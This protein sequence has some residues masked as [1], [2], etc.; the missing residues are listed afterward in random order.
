MTKRLYK[1]PAQA[2][3]TGV[4]AGIA[5]YF[6]IDPTV[7]R[8]LFVVAAF[9]TEGLA[10]VAYFVLA[11]ILPVNGDVTSSASDRSGNVFTANSSSSLRNWLGLGLIILGGWYL[12]SY[13]WPGIL[14]V[15]WNVVWPVVIIAIG[16]IILTRGKR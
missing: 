12:L 15:S 4:A 9:L 13:L 10:V 2:Q 7:V 6:N 14:V 1:I 8:V 3:I 11:I 5:D 16:I